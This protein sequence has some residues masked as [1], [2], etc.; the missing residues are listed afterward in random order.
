MLKEDVKKITNTLDVF[1]E[2]F[3]INDIE[4]LHTLLS[5]INLYFNIENDEETDLF[6]NKIKTFVSNTIH[7]KVIQSQPNG[8]PYIDSFVVNEEEC[9]NEKPSIY[10]KDS[11]PYLYNGENFYNLTPELQK[12][13][14]FQVLCPKS[15]LNYETRNQ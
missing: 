15:Y 12:A 11:H 13:F 7:K 1:I 4:D 5:L 9:C 10:C 3:D 2:N 6:A 8:D 14:S